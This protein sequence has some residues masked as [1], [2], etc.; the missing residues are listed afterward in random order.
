M[1]YVRW[2]LEVIFLRH[3]IVADWRILQKY[4]KTTPV[5]CLFRELMSYIM[6]S[7]LESKNY[8]YC[9]ILVYLKKNFGTSISLNLKQQMIM[10][11]NGT[12]STNITFFPLRASIRH[13]WWFRLSQR[14][15]VNIKYSQYLMICLII[16][17]MIC[18]II[19]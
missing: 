19:R 17:L 2:D 11:V 9:K 7:L 1:W 5:Q 3:S 6:N 12:K 15:F 4:S 10:M 14:E 8:R 13:L 18:L 16:L